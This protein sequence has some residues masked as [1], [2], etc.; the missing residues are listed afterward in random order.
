M[1]KSPK[2]CENKIATIITKKSLW[3]KKAKERMLAKRGLII[4]LNETTNI[5]Y[6]GQNY[7]LTLQQGEGHNLHFTTQEGFTYTYARMLDEEPFRQILDDFYLQKA[8]ELL[9]KKIEEWAK[10]MGLHPTKISF[11]KT[12]SQWGSCSKANAL[13]INTSVMKLPWHLIEYIIV[14]ELA[15]I[16]HKHHQKAFWELVAKYVP[17]TRQSRKELREYA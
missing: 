16:K 9:P 8:K 10:K 17:N 15:H 13:S 2:N 12:K 11:G 1:I 3:I 6:L 5:Y 14:H 7:P 4:T